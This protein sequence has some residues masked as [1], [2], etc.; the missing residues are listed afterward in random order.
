MV[1]DIEL[2]ESTNEKITAKC[3]KERKLL[4]FNLILILI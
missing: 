3:N 2:F 1:A 4:T